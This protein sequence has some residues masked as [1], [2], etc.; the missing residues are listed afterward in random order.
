MIAPTEIRNRQGRANLI[1]SDQTGFRPP[2]LCTFSASLRTVSDSDGTHRRATFS[3][4]V[5]SPTYALSLCPPGAF[6]TPLDARRLY[7]TSSVSASQQSLDSECPDTE[8]RT[9]CPA[10][11]DS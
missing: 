9:R 11:S 7:A 2:H 3:L 10:S 8:R 5:N 6:R 4:S 1:V